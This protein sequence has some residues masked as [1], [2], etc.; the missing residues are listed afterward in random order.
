MMIWIPGF[1]RIMWAL[2]RSLQ[3][4]QKDGSTR[5]NGTVTGQDATLRLRLD[6]ICD[7]GA[8]TLSVNVSH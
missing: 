3:L 1:Q 5:Q 7:V 2:E 4:A 8:H 6:I